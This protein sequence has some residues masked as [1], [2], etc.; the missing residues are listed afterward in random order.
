[1]TLWGCLRITLMASKLYYRDFENG[2]RN[3]SFR[4][5]GW[6]ANWWN[7]LTRPRWLRKPAFRRDCGYYRW[8]HV[9]CRRQC[10]KGVN[11]FKASWYTTQRPLWLKVRDFGRWSDDRT[12]WNTWRGLILGRDLS[13][14]IRAARTAPMPFDRNLPLNSAVD[15]VGLRN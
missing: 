6:W 3:L 8:G 15:R 14:R 11:A 5:T 7:R 9:I 10:P 13:T 4:M 1:M 2:W 12:V